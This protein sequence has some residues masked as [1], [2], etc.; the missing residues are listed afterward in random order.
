MMKLYAQSDIEVG[1]DC[2]VKR[3]SDGREFSGSIESILP[4]EPLPK[5]QGQEG[6]DFL[7]VRVRLADSSELLP[8]DAVLC[9]LVTSLF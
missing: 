4:P 9:S 8:G 7:P 2:T 6:V 1:M 5:E 3:S